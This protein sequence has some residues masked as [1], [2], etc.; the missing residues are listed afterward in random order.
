[1]AMT[2]ETVTC[3]PDCTKCPPKVKETCSCCPDNA[4]KSFAPPEWD[5]WY[6]DLRGQLSM[7]ELMYLAVSPEGDSVY[8]VI[9]QM[10]EK[11]IPGAVA[12]ES[13]KKEIA[14]NLG[15]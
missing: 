12:A 15:Q 2:R 5:Q 8:E 4:G 10:H 13:V 6:E 11:G 14:K 3:C 7:D 1:M 9:D